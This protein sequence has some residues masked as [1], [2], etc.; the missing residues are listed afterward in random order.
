MTNMNIP[1]GVMNNMTNKID[2]FLDDAEKI[3]VA[4]EE[5]K[6]K[7]Y[8]CVNEINDFESICNEEQLAKLNSLNI[9]CE[10]AL[11]A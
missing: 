2:E 1:R 11:S 6:S 3:T 5:F 4:L 8:D 9:R 10:G 7:W